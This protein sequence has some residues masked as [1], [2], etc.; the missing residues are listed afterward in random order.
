[1]C[2]NIISPDDVGIT[3]DSAENLGIELIEHCIDENDAFLFANFPNLMNCGGLCPLDEI[4]DTV[5]PDDIIGQFVCPNG[6]T[7]TRYVKF[8]TPGGG[9]G[10]IITLDG[11]NW[12]IDF[13]DF[14]DQDVTFELLPPPPPPTPLNCYIYHEELEYVQIRMVLR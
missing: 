7:V 3:E 6:E 11:E 8:C 14:G 12:R 13:C 5:D 1:M 9:T 4:I 2:W 10:G